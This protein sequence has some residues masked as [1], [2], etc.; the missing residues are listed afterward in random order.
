MLPPVVDQFV[1]GET[2]AGVLDHARRLNEDGI[3]AIVNRLGE[4][5]DDRMRPAADARRYQRLAA[6]I[7]DA[8]LRARLSVKPTQLGLAD[9]EAYFRENLEA[10]LEYAAARDV[11][12]WIDMEDHTSVEATLAAYEDMA[13]TYETVGICLQANLERTREDLERVAAAGGRVRL[14]KGGY[15]PPA[16]VTVSDVDAA[17]REHVQ[18]AF[19]IAELVAVGSHDPAMVALAAD[20]GQTHDT[21]YEIQM[22]AGVRSS[23][24]RELAAHHDVWQYVPYGTEWASYFYRRLTERKRNAAVAARAISPV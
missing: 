6:A 8:G 13:P 11:F 20:L 19:E 2:E 3:G 17:M 4:H 22:L 9:D 15:T 7:D 1:G 5:Y 10:V 18:T 14:V 23:A 21:G 24:Q 12:V 16:S